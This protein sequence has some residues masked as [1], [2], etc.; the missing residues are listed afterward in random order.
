MSAQL[1]KYVVETLRKLDD[2]G[3]LLVSMMKN[4]KRNVMTIGW[5]FVGILWRMPVFVVAVRPSRYTHEFLDDSGEFTVNV[6][7]DHMHDVVQYCGQVSGREHDKV[8]EC[9]LTLLDAKEVK[10]PFIK[11]CRIHYECRVVHKL[12]VNRDPA[13]AHA[14]LVLARVKIFLYPRREYSTLYFGKILA[15]Y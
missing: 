1:E 6:P 3:L 5:G 8:E 4:G 9:K 11:E 10:V 2:P 12:E 14:D 15:V 7:D 13:R